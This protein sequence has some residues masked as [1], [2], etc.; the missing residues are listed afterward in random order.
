MLVRVCRQ[1]FGKRRSLNECPAP[2]S[3]IRPRKRPVRLRLIT[4][5]IALRPSQSCPSSTPYHSVHWLPALRPRPP[6]H[7]GSRHPRPAHQLNLGTLA[8]SRDCRSSTRGR[9][10]SVCGLQTNEQPRTGAN[11]V[12]RGPAFSGVFAHIRC[13]SRF[14]MEIGANG[15]GWLSDAVFGGSAVFLRFGITF[16]GGR[17]TRAASCGL[18]CQSILT[19][20]ACQSK[21]TS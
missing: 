13:C 6:G 1:R 18:G 3:S 5:M 21:L 12:P 16:V 11:T 2:F 20:C 14:C 7:P 19:N 8:H 9:L 15:S 10:R 17:A 4:S